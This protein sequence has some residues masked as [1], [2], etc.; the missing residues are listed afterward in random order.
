[1]GYL[2]VCLS[3]SFCVYLCHFPLAIHNRCLSVV[4]TV[5]EQQYSSCAA[6]S[7]ELEHFSQGRP[8]T[9]RRQGKLH[10]LESSRCHQISKISFSWAKLPVS[11]TKDFRDVASVHPHRKRWSSPWGGHFWVTYNPI[12]ATSIHWPTNLDCTGMAPLLLMPQEKS[13]YS[14]QFDVDFKCFLFY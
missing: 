11:W 9:W 3:F 14:L 13:Q 1:M 5:P 6:F 8:I 12:V 7:S 4:L 10:R 2:K